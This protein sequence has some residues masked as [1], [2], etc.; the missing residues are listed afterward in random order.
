MIQRHLPQASALQG[1]PGARGRGARGCS[2]IDPGARRDHEDAVAAV[3][4]K[5]VHQAH[6]Q[7][8]IRSRA[9]PV[10][11]P[12]EGAQDAAAHEGAG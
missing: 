1:F 11:T 9:P 10:S 4:D 7:V 12:V 6:G 5:D 3:P 8:A 2:V